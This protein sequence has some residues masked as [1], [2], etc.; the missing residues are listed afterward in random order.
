DRKPTHRFSPE[1][2][3]GELCRRIA[4]RQCPTH[5]HPP[6]P[7]SCRA[8]TPSFPDLNRCKSWVTETC[9]VTGRFF[10]QCL[11]RANAAGSPLGNARGIT[12]PPCPASCRAPTSCCPDRNRCKSWM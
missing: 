10:P 3:Y 12:I 1:Q 8:P 9:P 2:P 11:F 7:T 4:A 6:C 5:H